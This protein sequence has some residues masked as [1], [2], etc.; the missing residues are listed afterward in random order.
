MYLCSRPDALLEYSLKTS[1]DVVLED[2]I[3]K[4]S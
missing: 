3:Y 2:G 1:S 4:A